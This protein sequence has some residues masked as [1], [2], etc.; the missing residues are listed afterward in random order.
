MGTSAGD[1]NK[2]GFDDVVVG[3]WLYDATHSNAG[4]AWL[5]LGSAAGLATSATW[6]AQVAQHNACFGYSVASAGDVNGDGFDDVVVGAPVYDNGE[7]DEGMSFVYL[8]GTTGLSASPAWTAESNQGGAYFGQS[9]ATAGD[10]N[11]D[12]FDD[13]I[14]GAQFYDGALQ[15]QGRA[16]V[17]LGSSAG[18]GA[19]AA[20]YGEQAQ[21]NERFGESVA[22]AGDV[23][24]DGFDDVIVGAWAYTAPNRGG[25]GRA[26]VYMG[27]ATGL[28]TTASWQVVGNQSSAG[29]GYSAGSAGDVN[30]DGYGDVIVGADGYD[31]GETNE[32]RA[33]VYFGAA[34]GLPTTA[35][36]TAESNQAGA[37]FGNS[38][39]SAGD[40]NGDGAADILVGAPAYD[41]GA[42]DEGRA[43]LYLGIL[44]DADGD[45][46]T[47]T[48]DCDDGDASVHPGA[49]EVCNGIDDDC[50]GT[51]DTG[52]TDAASDADAD[53]SCDRVDPDDDG[54]G[55]LD[56]ADAFPLDPTESADTDADGVGDNTDVFPLDASESEDADGDEV[57][58]NAD[59]CDAV[60]ATGWDLDRDGCIDDTDADGAADDV[61]QCPGFDD[62][63]DDDLDG[64]ADGCDE[65]PG[66]PLN[67]QDGDGFC[68]ADDL[69]P[70][71]FGADGGLVDADGDGICDDDDGCA[72]GD[73]LL[74]SD[75]DALADACD[76]CAFDADNDADDDGACG[77]VDACDFTGSADADADGLP[78]LCDTLCP[79]DPTNDADFDGACGE[80]DLCPLD[81][82][83]D[84]DGDGSC[85]TDDVCPGLDDFEDTDGDTLVDCRDSCPAD[86][87]NDADVDGFCES[88]DNC[89]GIS[90]ADQADADADG[91]GNVCEPDSDADGVID[92]ADNCDFVANAAQPDTDG[93]GL[94]DACDADSDGDGVANGSDACAGSPL[95]APVLSSGCTIDQANPCGAAWK[96]HGAYVSAVTHS[97]NA[98]KA[99]GKLTDTQT[100]AITSAAAATT[101]GQ[102]R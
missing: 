23:N 78:D 52:A 28:A 16:F 96:N 59:A 19:T 90:N 93:D 56:G 68:T 27:A 39:A 81:A 25:Q 4:R 9:V 51:V 8:G 2:D 92:D 88:D 24:G 67:D 95:G 98:L 10:V 38:V 35:S 83:D 70:Q 97:A 40:V 49:T 60:D 44:D 5:Y 46:H 85:D 11:G 80:S 91:I 84:S 102:R 3:A 29:M 74:D 87:E 15:D 62:D 6:T 12:G 30:G 86:V 43:Y 75:G 65:C 57:G 76:G 14:V 17:Y 58:D 18:L 61:D 99:A 7:G 26:V 82:L 21:G 41:G 94:G 55:V 50:D 54:D 69:C 33:F 31:N 42:T 20:W 48:T 1:V 71:D 89:E 73:D 36:W 77:D 22:S 53:G 101:C 47:P 45:G 72:L 13:V 79:L 64:A 100:G 63:A 32:G 66:D 34:A 37:Q